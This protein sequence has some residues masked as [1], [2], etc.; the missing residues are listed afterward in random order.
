MDPVTTHQIKIAKKDSY[1]RQLC[2]SVPISLIFICIVISAQV[3]VQYANYYIG[4]EGNKVPTWWKYIPGI[5]N[6]LL[7]AIF[8]KIYGIICKRLLIFEN[9]RYISS[10]ENSNVNK[11]YMFSFINTYIGNFVAII[12]NQNFSALSLNLF[13]VMV[14]KQV[15]FNVYEFFSEKWTVGKKIR[16]VDELFEPKIKDAEELEKQ[17]GEDRLGVNRRVAVAD[18]KMHCEIEKQLMMKQAA[19]SL[20]PYY[21]EAVIQLGFIAFFAVSFP[22]APLFS[23]L[24]NLLEIQIKLQHIAKY[25]KRNQAQCTS[26]V[27]NW[28]PIMSFIG[29][30]AIPCNTLILIMCRFPKDQAGLGEDLDA[31]ESIDE[32]SILEQFFQKRDPERWTRTNVIIVAVLVEHIVIALKIVIHLII[33][34]VPHAV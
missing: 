10:F 27:G 11:I 18:L 29:Y 9:H 24:T 21:N 22:F 25:G 12:Y 13:T 7:I 14:F 23:F 32:K 33:P 20:V 15:V 19:N 26:G 2:V 3:G 28:A 17:G 4:D 34:D 30:F 16:Q 1:W 31:V 8:A 5:L 6:A